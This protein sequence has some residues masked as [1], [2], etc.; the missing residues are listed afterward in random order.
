MK[1]FYLWENLEIM[2]KKKKMKKIKNFK[3]NFYKKINFFG[4]FWTNFKNK[5]VNFHEKIRKSIKK[6]I[7][8]DL[9]SKKCLKIS[10]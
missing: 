8:F 7:I 3:K 10:I 6:Y 1:D 5:W 9:K 4:R 2:Q